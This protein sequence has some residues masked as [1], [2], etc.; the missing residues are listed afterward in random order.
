MQVCE[1]AAVDLRLLFRSYQMIRN[2]FRKRKQHHQNVTVNTGIEEFVSAR[3]T[4][5]I[6]D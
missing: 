5:L 4:S 2:N 3:T 6:I 1:V